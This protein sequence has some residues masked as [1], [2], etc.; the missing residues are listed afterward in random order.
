M[1]QEGRVGSRSRGGTLQGSQVAPSWTLQGNVTD[2]EQSGNEGEE[3]PFE[4][5]RVWKAF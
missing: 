2:S 5:R 1:G 3:R 4:S